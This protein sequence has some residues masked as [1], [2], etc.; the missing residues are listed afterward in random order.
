M[1]PYHDENEAL[2]T[3]YVTYAIIALNVLVWIVAEGAGSTL[4]M[5][6][7]SS[8]STALRL[9][10]EA[11]RRLREPASPS[12]PKGAGSSAS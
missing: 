10:E 6:P 4:S 1:F 2:R 5:A 8:S 9:P 11:P 3:P 12:S 7:R